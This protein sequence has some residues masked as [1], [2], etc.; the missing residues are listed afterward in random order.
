MEKYRYFTV[1]FCLFVFRIYSQ[2][3]RNETFKEI[4]ENYEELNSD[5]ENAIPFIRLY[6]SKAKNES[7]Y[8]N[9]IQ[10]Y[11]DARQY[12]A[13]V[14]TKLKYADSTIQIALN[15]KDNDEICKGYM[16]KGIVYYFN[17]KKYKQALDE[18]LKA[19]KY[20]KNS[21]DEYLK[22]KIIY[23]LGVVKSY[24]GYYDESIKH[25]ENC[26]DFFEEKTKEEQHPNIL[27]NMRKA[28][29]NSLH[30]MSI[31]YRNLNNLK[32]SDSLVSLGYKLTENKNEFRLE[33]SYFLKCRGILKF[34][35]KDYKG[36]LVDLN[37]S[38]PGLLERNDFAWVSVV[39]LYI[40][41]IKVIDKDYKCAAENF[42][43]IDSIFN[44]NHFILPEVSGN[45]S[46]LINY[47]HEKKN[48]GKEIY[49]AKQLSE[50]KNLINSD[51]PYLSSK[52]Y[53][54]YDSV[55][56]KDKISSLEHSDRIKDRIVIGLIFL[57]IFLCSF[58]I[59]RFHK[60]K[61]IKKKYIALQERISQ[62]KLRADRTFEEIQKTKKQVISPELAE[63][64]LLK[65]NKF[66]SK[67][68][69][70]QQG[71]TQKILADN[72]GTNSNYL[73]IL[74]NERKQVNFNRYISELRINYITNLLNTDRKFL[75]YKMEALANECG[76]CGRQNFSKVFLKSTEF[77]RP[78]L[79]PIELG[80]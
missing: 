3:L 45:Y 66:E 11:N 30:Q 71:L 1:V 64:I 78:I 51:F 49:Y 32:K 50:A 57:A 9:L 69:Y 63:Q 22:H 36:A 6:I 61:Q 38:L 42:I 40:G 70:T 80:N 26:I 58:F 5:N 4:R 60:H 14:K 19:F 52:V 77:V 68:L 29:Y 31:A 35:K 47:Y 37:N 34:K 75:H 55:N 72:L 65:L 44:K 54:E 16:S 17:E 25:F 12:S 8:K 15:H 24:L 2:N 13:S 59:F 33:K 53:N 20:S 43:K 62:S 27:F 7:D 41:K 74:I 10:G 23:H 67:N 48:N 46:F 21:E 56:F 79:F 39:Y 18:Y 73:S 28:Y 76:I